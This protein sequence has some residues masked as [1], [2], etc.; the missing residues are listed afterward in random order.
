MSF[1]LI[2]NQ[3]DTSKYRVTEKGHRFLHLL[4]EMEQISKGPSTASKVLEI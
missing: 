4:E 1:G 3:N 2:E